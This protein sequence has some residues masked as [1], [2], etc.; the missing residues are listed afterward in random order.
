MLTKVLRSVLICSED[1]LK[2][3]AGILVGISDDDSEYKPLENWLQ[4]I[5]KK[6]D[7]V[8]ILFLHKTLSQLVFFKIIIILYYLIYIYI[9]NIPS[10]RV[11]KHE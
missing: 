11:F 9:Y 3:K 7:V 2:K 10:E 6:R 4:S 8:S 5:S 1:C